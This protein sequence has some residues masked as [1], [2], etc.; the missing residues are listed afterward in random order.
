MNSEKH[1]KR[2]FIENLKES[3]FIN[4][5]FA[6]KLKKSPRPY[7]KG[8][9]FD[10]ILSDKTGEI[11]VKYWGGD[12]KEKVK[13]IFDGFSVGDVIEVHNGTVESYEDKL[14]ISINEKTGS[15]RKC[16]PGEY[17][18]TDFIPALEENVITRLFE[19]LKKDFQSIQNQPLKNLLA[20]FFNDPDFVH[21]YT[22][23]PSAITHHHNYVGGNLEHAVGVARICKTI[24]EFYPNI[25][26]DLLITGA[27]LHDVGKIREYTYTAAIDKSDE[28]NFIG[29]IVIGD[30]WIREKINEIRTQG[31]TF[32]LELENHLSHLILSHHG[33]YE[34]GSP[35]MPKTVEA[36]I[37]HYA[38]LMDSQVKNFIQTIENARKMSDDEWTYIYDGDL[39]KKRAIFLG[40][41]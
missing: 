23:S 38:D 11:V 20:S 37:L 21:T 14:Q 8:L 24:V 16:T 15:L 5:L 10:C 29:H 2:Q 22:H 1:A 25:N 40:E 39:G 12:N 19:T 28:G 41:Y 27:I 36:C 7:R 34:W 18:V 9:F 35:R 13:R 17:D 30:R 4:D 6:V 3:D 26:R 33:R 31:V 32:P